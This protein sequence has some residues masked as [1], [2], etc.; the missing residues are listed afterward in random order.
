ME[1]S[2]NNK[3]KIRNRSDNFNSFDTTLLINLVKKRFTYL[4]SNDNV[5]KKKAWKTIWKQ[6]N[7]S[8]T[9]GERDLN[10]LKN[11][12]KNLKA[13]K[14]KD[15]FEIDPSQ[16]IF[17]LWNFEEN[18][19]VD[20]N[21]IITESEASMESDSSDNIDASSTTKRKRKRT[22]NF[23]DSDTILLSNLVEKYREEVDST[24]IQIKEKAWHEI[25]E[26][27]NLNQSGGHRSIASLRFK[28]K[29][30]KAKMR[31][32]AVSDDK[33]EYNNS[34]NK[35]EYI[36]DYASPSKGCIVEEYLE[37]SSDEN[38]IEI[39][40]S[41]N[42]TN[43]RK[44]KRCKDFNDIDTELIIKLVD[45][46]TDVLN[47]TNATIKNK[48]WLKIKKEFNISQTGMERDVT[49]LK[50]KYKNLKAHRKD[51]ITS[52][53]GQERICEIGLAELSEEEDEEVDLRKY[54]N[55]SYKEDFFETFS[56]PSTSSKIHVKRN[57]SDNF[58]EEDTKLL[59]KL[60][61]QYF[62]EI[63]DT[64]FSIKKEAWQTIESKFNNQQSG[65]QRSI[66]ALRNR[67]KNIKAQS[68]S[69]KEETA[70]I[71]RR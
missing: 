68:K 36:I 61:L 9:G 20:E 15:I 6:Y 53:A 37:R 69:Q 30:L 19:E 48:A 55:K 28:Y 51:L 12:Y 13:H 24:N 64:K 44:R 65:G 45:K 35:S 33:Q 70:T 46:Y 63:N 47:S 57:R 39:V 25:A 7:A 56:S 17:Q 40:T 18:N 66:L 16:N 59:I 58:N 14:S 27:Y 1:I 42:S 67:Y 62:D 71:H 32:E 4:K 60:V 26:N 22:G 43:N 49:G 50:T 11:K 5:A 2:M 23:M 54:E 21:S 38:E 34:D 52:L 29:N 31:K 41:E 10:S 8:Q 3:H